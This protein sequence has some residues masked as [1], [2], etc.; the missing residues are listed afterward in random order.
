MSKINLS[1]LFSKIAKNK[2]N[3]PHVSE[4]PQGGN[5]GDYD[6]M[7]CINLSLNPELYQKL[8]KK[9]YTLSGLRR[10]IQ[11][12]IHN[13]L[14]HPSNDG[15]SPDI[16][17]KN[18]RVKIPISSASFEKLRHRAYQ[19]GCLNPTDYVRALLYLDLVM[20]EDMKFILE[21]DLKSD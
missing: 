15:N 20:S 6:Y 13:D 21:E 19:A 9:Y 14:Y 16:I 18:N 4:L 5:F 2:S 17:E 3:L 8:K 12:L 1:E 11:Y 10:H 7:K